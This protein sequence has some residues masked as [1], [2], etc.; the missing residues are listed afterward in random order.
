MKYG[1]FVTSLSLPSHGY[2]ARAI[3]CLVS[4]L[5]HISHLWESRIPLVSLQQSIGNKTLDTMNLQPTAYST[6]YMNHYSLYPECWFMVSLSR[7]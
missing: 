7:K 4:S 6:H 1:N 3:L 5:L 2:Q